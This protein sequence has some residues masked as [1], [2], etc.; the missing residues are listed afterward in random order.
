MNGSLAFVVTAIGCLVA[1]AGVV[2][3]VVALRTARKRTGPGHGG[4]PGRVD[5]FRGVDDDAD[6]LRGDPRRLAPGDIVEIRGTSYGV[7]GSLRLAE[8]DW[9]WWEHLIDDAAGGQ[10]WLSVEE[11]PDL[12]MV[13]WTRVPD[14]TVAPGPPTVDLDGR[15]Y[16]S[17]ESGR[18][19]FTSTGSTGLN[20]AGTMSYHDYRA[21]DGARLSFESW[22]DSPTW[23]VSRGQQLHRAEVVIYPQAGQQP[24]K[25]G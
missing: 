6:A 15:R 21:P 4:T 2:V 22:G 14:V 5:P 20:P 7:R 3:A 13:L 24:G 25:V 19:R 16:T 10:L 17:R 12:E 11:D 23:E 9:T 8:G 1:V 18:A